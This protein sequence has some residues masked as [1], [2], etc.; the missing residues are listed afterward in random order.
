[1]IGGIM[2]FYHQE[3]IFL[4]VKLFKFSYSKFNYFFEKSNKYVINTNTQL[5]DG[6]IYDFLSKKY[7]VAISSLLIETNTL[8]KINLF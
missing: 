8:K 1:M 3:K 4:K 7:L 2:I 5:P 6:K